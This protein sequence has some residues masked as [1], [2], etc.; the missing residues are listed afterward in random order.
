[1]RDRMVTRKQ[2]AAAI[3]TGL[4]SPLMRV[5]P[6]SSV[7]LAGKAAWLSVAPAFLALLA[8]M[9]LMNAL[10]RA[11]LPGEGMA[12][13]LLRVLGPWFGRLALL[14]YAA[15][16]LFYAGFLLRSG[17]ERLTATVYQQS[18]VT[19]FIVVML[20]LC[21]LAALGTLRATVRT[22]TARCA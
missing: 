4:L 8:L 14:L 20:A 2:F 16:F 22:A 12:N 11:L 15:W 6:R 13:L 17:A 21:L 3:F 18:A 10:R 9:A 1:M 5:L 7:L 19:P